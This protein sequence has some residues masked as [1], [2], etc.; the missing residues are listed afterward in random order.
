MAANGTTSAA[1]RAEQQSQLWTTRRGARVIHSSAIVAGGVSAN[2]RT[3]RSVRIE[4]TVDTGSDRRDVAVT[5]AA[6]ATVAEVL[7]AVAQ[8]VGRTEASTGW[9]GD[10][11][12]PGAARFEATGVRTGAQ[13]RLDRPGEPVGRAAV[14]SLHIVGGPDAGRAR[15][16][17]RGR[18]TIGRDPAADVQLDDPDVSRRHAAIEVGRTVTVRDLGS[19]NG[20]RVDGVL[21]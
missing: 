12:L 16:L 8:A 4:F 20:T 13:L 15:P 7:P 5:A 21:L 14:L 3:L 18:L 17:E 2:R 19:T 10:R 1:D 11:A 6:G 9:L